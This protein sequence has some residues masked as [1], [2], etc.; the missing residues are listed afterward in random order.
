M[1]MIGH[2]TAEKMAANA[3]GANVV[4]PKA[5][6]L[7]DS[8]L[9]FLSIRDKLY[10]LKDYIHHGE[11]ERPIPDQQNPIPSMSSIV[12]LLENAPLFLEELHSD[13][14]RTITEIHQS[15]C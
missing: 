9:R 4:Q 5:S 1:T 10:H 7:A 3:I 6:T 11:A 8:I 15:L 14:D 13:I 2:N 12:L